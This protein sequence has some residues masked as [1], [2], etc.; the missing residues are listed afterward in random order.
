M[1]QL[2]PHSPFASETS[3]RTPI[4]PASAEGSCRNSLHARPFDMDAFKRVFPER[5]TKFLR[6]HFR[7][8]DEVQVFFGVSHRMAEYYWNGGNFKPSGHLVAIAGAH[9]GPKFY[10][11]FPELARAA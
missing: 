3:S 4:T 6:A 5:W 1:N 7:S 10:H 11:H 9:F 8:A 2:S